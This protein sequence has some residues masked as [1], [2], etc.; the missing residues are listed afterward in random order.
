MK[1]VKD[2]VFFWVL[3]LKMSF[4][5]IFIVIFV[6]SKSKYVGVHSFKAIGGISLSEVHT[7][8]LKKK[9][10]NEF[11]LE[12]LPLRP[13]IMFTFK[14]TIYIVSKMIGDHFTV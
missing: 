9:N 2:K 4:V 11:L 12:H 1:N 14:V 8:N 5:S 7:R 6:I 3:T 10:L 13:Y